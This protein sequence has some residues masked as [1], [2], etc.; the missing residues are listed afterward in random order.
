[1]SVP[2]HSSARRR[3]AHL[4][5]LAI[6]SA[7]LPG[8]AAAAAKLGADPDRPGRLLLDHWPREGWTI[9]PTLEGMTILLRGERLEIALPEAGPGAL[10]P[11]LSALEAGPAQ[12]GTALFLG[13]T[14]TC[15]VVLQGDAA[16]GLAI[17]IVESQ[18]R[19][20]D[21]SG[22]APVTAPSPPSRA[23]PA[24]PDSRP[25]AAPDD[26]DLAEVRRRLITQIERA[27]EA[28]LITLAEPGTGE[29]EDTA[30]P[31][32]D[33]IPA[34]ESTIL[35]EAGTPSSASART[36]S[37][38]P[39]GAAGS[40]PGGSD[41]RSI[42]VAPGPSNPPQEASD[43][44]APSQSAAATPVVPDP[45]PEPVPPACQ[46]DD[47]FELPDPT[48]H[49]AP[50][51]ETARLGRDILG[52]FDRPRP[53]AVEALARHHISLGLGRET[54]VLLAELGA[55]LETAPLLAAMAQIVEGDAPM[56]SGLA[57]TGCSGA[58]A[59]W[60]AVA[61]AQA[62][63]HDDA[64]A[65]AARSGR[66]LQTVPT[67]LRRHFAA[68]IGLSAAESGDWV[69]AQRMLS[70]A[71]RGRSAA[72]PASVAEDLLAARL[73]AAR[74][75]GATA[76][77]ALRRVWSRFPA[78][79]EAGEGLIALADL[80]MGDTLPETGDTRLLRLDLGSLALTARG[81]PLGERAVAAEAGLTAL[82]YGPAAGVDLLALARRQ[83]TIS[84]AGYVAAVRTL[85]GRAPAG[86]DGEPLALR[87]EREPDRYRPVLADPAFRAALALSYA[88]IGWPE[89]TELFLEPG[90]LG[91]P[92]LAAALARSYLAAGMP[93]RAETIA[94]RLPAG[95]GRAEIMAAVLEAGG[96][97]ARALALLTRA[98]TG[99]A[100]DRARLA[101]AAG[102]WSA[103]AS[104]L[105][106][107]AV[108]DPDPE[109]E[110]R[111]ALARERA[112][113][114]GAETVGQAGPAPAAP[115]FAPTPD[116][117]SRYLEA[118]RAEA[119]TMRQV[120]EDG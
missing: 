54:I 29:T 81:S 2:P 119:E 76:L 105:A 68:R 117:V 4:L 42:T 26:P 98:E 65:A 66:A 38:P 86:E 113:E 116:G 22:P 120:L 11:A 16:T 50:L 73:A 51:A 52:E 64:L 70:M 77:T 35:A 6:V 10:H 102:N 3:A 80:V 24:S 88:E 107:A 62:G 15:S 118:L 12:G 49:A 7:L 18:P 99:T 74:D 63:A 103:A 93:E 47:A 8:S 46:P 43:P 95:A 97:P 39:E 27:A 17:D 82:A 60:Q 79:P 110:A 55:G 37:L 48:R 92:R 108:T 96:E 87:V 109:T 14:C 84:E 94:T 53:A 36:G 69:A 78:D 1:M 40:L 30:P 19:S 5:V 101:W 83:G 28:G 20:R 85:S 58:H 72:E 9:E 104:A 57:G 25:E 56:G 33:P 21:R 91:R 41:A 32:A 31:T 34:P 111:L 115:A 61:A 67:P 112:A 13:L 71:G 114:A 106:D 45:V 100:R 44:S 59:L 90:D 75:D 89:R 23:T